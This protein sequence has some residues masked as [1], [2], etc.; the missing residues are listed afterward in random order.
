[1]ENECVGSHLA[2]IVLSPLHIL[3]PA[4]RTLPALVP[5]QLDATPDVLRYPPVPAGF[6]DSA[7]YGLYLVPSLLRGDLRQI[8][9]SICVL[10]SRACRDGC[11]RGQW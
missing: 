9:G 11:G 7:V 5:A 10:E 8:S 4:D 2:T 6:A 3:L 1:M